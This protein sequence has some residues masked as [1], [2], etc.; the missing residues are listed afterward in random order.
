M[1]I[2]KVLKNVLI[3]IVLCFT[4]ATLAGHLTSSFW[5]RYVVHKELCNM[6]NNLYRL[7]VC[8]LCEKVYLTYKIY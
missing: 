5:E 3:E 6:K 1:P 4:I 8:N 2:N 7:K